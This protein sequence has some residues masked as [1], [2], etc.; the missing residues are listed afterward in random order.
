M[1]GLCASRPDSILSSLD[2]LSFLLQEAAI[3]IL[4]QVR[5]VGPAI[6]A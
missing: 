4:E 6:F 5:L 2:G 1:V 3:R